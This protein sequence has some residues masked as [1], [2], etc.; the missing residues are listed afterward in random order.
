MTKKTSK[1]KG[2]AKKKSED[3]GT[4]GGLPASYD[5]KLL[6]TLSEIRGCSGHEDAVRKFIVERIRSY[7]DE[8]KFDTMGNIYAIKYGL[9]KENSVLLC[10]HMDE[11]GFMVKYIDSNGFIRL[12]PVGG[13]NPRM[14]PGS[15]III[16]GKNG[17]IQGIFGEKAAHLLEQSEKSKVSKMEELFVDIGCGNKEE[18]EKYV[19][20][21]DFA[22]FGQ[23]FMRFKDSTRVCGKAMD[24]RA[25]CY[26]LLRTAENVS[27]LGKIPYTVIYCFSVQEE[28]GLRGASIVG[29][30]VKVNSAL[31]VE[32]THGIDYPGVNKEKHGDIELG[33][34]PVIGLGPN[35]HPKISSMLIKCA[36][37]L[38]IAFQIEAEPRPTGTDARVLQVTGRGI[39]VG[40]LSIPI[41][42]MHTIIETLD[43]RDLENAVKLIT[44]YITGLPAEDYMIL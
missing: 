43:V 22:E 41:R 10:A 24:D 2:T 8:I 17:E 20:V 25:G 38:G 39:P 37:K 5:N 1:K 16:S 40:L 30:N 29:F 11:I 3:S 36:N 18:A 31:V 7:C 21:G 19:T 15:K 33:K 32:V 23:T 27:K 12:T 14:L 6:K 42:Y 28:V 35:L 26:V 44:E 9:N 4:R 34:G 13:Q